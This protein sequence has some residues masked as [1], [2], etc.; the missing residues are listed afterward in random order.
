MWC[1]M[2]FLLWS[3]L[4]CLSFTWLFTLDLYTLERDTWWI[5]LLVSGILC[6]TAACRGKIIFNTLDKKYPLL[7]IYKFALIARHFMYQGI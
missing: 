3:G 6:N 2:S 5:I 4:F 1:I 7:L